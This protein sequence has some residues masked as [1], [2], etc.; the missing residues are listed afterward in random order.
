[1]TTGEQ[2]VWGAFGG[3]LPSLL[4]FVRIGLLDKSRGIDVSQIGSFFVVALI[5]SVVLGAIASY[6]FE[7]NHKIPA[8]YNGGTAPLALAFISGVDP[9]MVSAAVS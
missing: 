3:I 6:V 1:M 7:S 2:L 5:L 9:H 4:Q 8:I